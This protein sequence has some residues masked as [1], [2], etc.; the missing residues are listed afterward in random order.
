MSYCLQPHGLQSARLFYLW[1]FSG[2]NTGIGCHSLLQGIFLTQGLN[3]HP[4][5][6]QADSLSLSHLGCPTSKSVYLHH[7]RLPCP[8]PSPRVCPNLCPWSRWCHPNISAS[9]LSPSSPSALNLFQHQG[10]FQWVSSLHHVAEGL[11]LQLQHQSFQWI[12]MV[13]FIRTDWSDLLA[14]FLLYLLWLNCT[15]QSNWGGSPFHITVV[16]R[17]CYF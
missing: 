5:Y 3:P 4:L 9:A 14:T 16:L 13:I 1:D 12:F 15:S 2:N 7:A 8:S 10:V 11:E 17:P 6:W